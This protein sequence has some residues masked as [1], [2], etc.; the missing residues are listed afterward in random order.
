MV[1]SQPR[2]VLSQDNHLTGVFRE[3]LK[4]NWERTA[5]AQ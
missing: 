3:P 1:E 4:H 2:L 5:V